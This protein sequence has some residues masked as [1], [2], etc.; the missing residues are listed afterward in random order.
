MAETKYLMVA[1][2]QL[3]RTY[4]CYAF[5]SRHD[6]MDDPLIIFLNPVWNAGSRQLISLNTPTCL[7]FDKD[8]EFVAFGYDAENQYADVML[9][10]ETDDYYFFQRFT[11]LLHS[12][13]VFISEMITESIY[14]LRS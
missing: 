7:L 6:F 8:K 3:G 13:K 14:L 4:S 2:L 5:S 1:S 10:G 11:T 9:D 12:N